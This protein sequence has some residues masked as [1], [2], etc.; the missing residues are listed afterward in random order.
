MKEIIINLVL[1]IALVI[2]ISGLTSCTANSGANTS[3]N[4]N[5]NTNSSAQTSSNTNSS[6]TKSSTYPEL[7]P[8][9]AQA[10][11]E[12]LD[13][14]KVKVADRKGK[15]VL[16]NL[17]ATWCGPCRAEMPEIV[18]MYDK[19][20]DNGFQV[21][22]LDIGDGNGRPEE[23]ADIKSFGEK[24]K[25]NYEL[26]RI[27]SDTTREINKLTGFDAVPQTLL[28]DREGRLRGVF[29]GGGPTVI[30]KMKET[31]DKVMSEQ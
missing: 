8:A 9:I 15:V 3:V 26:A 18:S 27:T 7:K 10:D 29:L 23:I 24:M 19:Y 20:K 1:F 11:L 13:G 17:W 25:L 16:L 30:G 31:V 21:I 6:E 22:G 2:A 4:S 12:L 28:I 5:T 14:S